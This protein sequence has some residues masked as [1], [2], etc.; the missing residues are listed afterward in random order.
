[1]EET[2]IAAL[3]QEHKRLKGQIEE[4][5]ARL[6]PDET[7]LAELKRHKLRIKDQIAATGG[8]P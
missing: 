4:E 8:Q 1:M 6:V 7:R 2:D 5:S 3:Q